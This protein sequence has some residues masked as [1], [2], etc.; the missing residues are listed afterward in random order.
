[1][2]LSPMGPDSRLTE[3]VFASGRGGSVGLEEGAQLLQ[4]PFEEEGDNASG[5]EAEITSHLAGTELL[6]ASGDMGRLY[7]RATWEKG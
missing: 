1:M 6:S 4:L 2:L 5:S 7:P 3:G